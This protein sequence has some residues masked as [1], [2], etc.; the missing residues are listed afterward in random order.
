MK[1]EDYLNKN[2]VDPKI[3]NEQ[4]C[5]NKP[6]SHIVFD[7]FLKRKLCDSILNEFPNLSQ[8]ENRIEFKDQKQIKL[9]S[10]GF[11]DIKP[12]AEK[13]IT[14]LNSDVFLDY[15]KKLTGI[16]RDLISDPY[17]SGGG[18]HEIKNGG[19][20]KV[21]ADFNK[22]PHLDLDRRLNLLLYLNK[23]W[24]NSWGGNLELYSKNQFDKPVVS[25]RPL[26]NRCVIFTTKSDTFHGHPEP[27]TCPED[28]SRKS[29]ALYYFTTGRPLEENK[30]KHS[31]IFQATKGEKILR[32]RVLRKVFYKLTPPLISDLIRNIKNLIIKS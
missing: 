5:L 27:I 3:F 30:D 7:D 8:I 20:L 22:H 17:L 25:V 1:I 13:L 19:L 14:F 23:D 29:I 16:E 10:R 31:T 12:N 15:L 21:H 28:K 18:Y 11:G 2:Y 24:Q 26:F 9:A 6:F 4:Y 32:E